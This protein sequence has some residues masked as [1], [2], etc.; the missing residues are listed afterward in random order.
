MKI[1]T[2]FVEINGTWYLRCPPT[3]A[4]FLELDLARAFGYPVPGGVQDERGKKGKY[5]SAWV[6]VVK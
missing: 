4:K 3:L 1:E 5:I 6:E 2:T